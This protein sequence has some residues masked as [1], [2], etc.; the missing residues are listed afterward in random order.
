MQYNS[1][2]GLLVNSIGQ[3]SHHS[4]RKEVGANDETDPTKVSGTTHSEST[5]LETPAFSEMEQSQMQSE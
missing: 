5:V 1:I 3:S 4:S 2:G